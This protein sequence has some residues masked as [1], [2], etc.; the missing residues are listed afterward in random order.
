[1]NTCIVP[2][3]RQAVFFPLSNLGPHL[4]EGIAYILCVEAGLTVVAVDQTTD[5]GDYAKDYDWFGT[6]PA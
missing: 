6:G 4:P 3:H 2:H 5:G 1:M